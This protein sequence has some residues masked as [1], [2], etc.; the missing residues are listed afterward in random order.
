[1]CVCIQ[2]LSHFHSV[3]LLSSVQLGSVFSFAHSRT[4]PLLHP[5]KCQYTGIPLNKCFLF[6]IHIPIFCCPVRLPPS[7]THSAYRVCVSLFHPDCCLCLQLCLCV[8]SFSLFTFLYLNCAAE[9]ILGLLLLLFLL[10]FR[11]VPTISCRIFV[12]LLFAPLVVVA[13]RYKNGSI[14]L[15]SAIWIQFLF[16][17]FSSPCMAWAKEHKRQT[18]RKPEDDRMKRKKICV[19]VWTNVM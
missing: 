3:R 14:A 15:Q 16:I 18:E 7:P 8:A 12:L 6:S 19:C 9:L 1:M 13:Q 2:M 17:P 11:F 10:C 4:F 5:Y